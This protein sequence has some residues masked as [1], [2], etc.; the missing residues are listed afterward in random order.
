MGIVR[1]ALKFGLILLVVVGIWRGIVNFDQAHSTNVFGRVFTTIVN[2]VQ[3]LT[4]R[5]VG[6]IIG[7]FEG[8]GK[9]VPDQ[10]DHLTGK[11]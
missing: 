1:T 2:T 10:V 7:W 8:F 3:D 4:Y 5:W 11:S 6:S 9:S